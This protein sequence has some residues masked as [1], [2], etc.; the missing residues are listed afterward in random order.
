MGTRNSRDAC[1]KAHAVKQSLSQS[2]EDATRPA[3]IVSIVFYSYSL[4]GVT[5]LAQPTPYQLDIANFPYPLSYRALVRVD[6]FRIYG[7]ALRFLKLESS[8]Q[9]T[10]KIW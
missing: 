8:R 6:P 10:V 4:E 7:K 2:P 3:A 1:L 9:P 5:F